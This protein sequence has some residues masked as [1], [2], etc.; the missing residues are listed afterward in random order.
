MSEH[1]WF[2]E[3][4]IRELRGHLGLQRGDHLNAATLLLVLD[5]I[6]VV[7]AAAE[8]IRTEQEER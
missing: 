7:A 3:D 5:C 2:T 6:D 4:E 8:R 1:L